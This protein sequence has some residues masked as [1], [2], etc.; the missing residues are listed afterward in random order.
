M[1]S[2]TDPIPNAPGGSTGGLGGGPLGLGS[3]GL[4][5]SCAVAAATA[6]AAGAGGVGV[7]VAAGALGCLG[8]ST[9]PNDWVPCSFLP[10]VP[11]GE[12]EV[13]LG[14]AKR[15]AF[16]SVGLLGCWIR[17]LRPGR[18]CLYGCNHAACLLGRP[19]AAALGWRHE[20]PL[21][22]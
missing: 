17:L 1:V 13:A 16:T 3:A 4:A 8:A 6:G 15:L 5:P 18:T 9:E 10:G 11:A 14:A 20:P 2:H 22:I 7:S 21:C 12:A 19:R